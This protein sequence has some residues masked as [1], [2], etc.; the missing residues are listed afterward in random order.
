VL[1]VEASCDVFIVVAEEI[2]VDCG[3]LYDEVVFSLLD[4]SRLLIAIYFM[5]DSLM[6]L[7]GFCFELLHPLKEKRSKK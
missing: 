2:G 7:V 5:V 3:R 1:V 6:L 4:S